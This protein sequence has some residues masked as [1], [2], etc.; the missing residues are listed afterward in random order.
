MAI[1]HLS[2]ELAERN[3]S[4]N[5]NLTIYDINSL[6]DQLHENRSLF[7]FTFFL[8]L[9]FLLII[10]IILIVIIKCYDIFTNS[11]FS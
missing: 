4:S 8:S 9:F 11:L 7:T 3:S 5:K 1:K 2:V 6:L 10:D